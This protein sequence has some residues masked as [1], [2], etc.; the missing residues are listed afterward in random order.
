ML[1][2]NRLRIMKTQWSDHRN[3]KVI[4]L[5]HCLLNENTRYMGGAVRGGVNQEILDL[6]RGCSV[7]V[8]Q[9]ICPERI[10]WG[11]VYKMKMLQ[12]HGIGK[13]YLVSRVC[14]FCLPL[15][16][17]WLNYKM[18]WVAKYTAA[19]IKDYI[20][21]GMCVIGVVGVGGS[22]ACG[23]EHTPDLRRYF[24][25]A[26]KA[27][28]RTVTAKEHNSI[29]ENITHEGQGTFI[30]YLKRR[31]EKDNVNIPFFEY[32]LWDEMRGRDNSVTRKLRTH[33]AAEGLY[34]GTDST[35]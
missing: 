14:A 35:V 8:I 31:L 16:M 21:N 26:R 9:M 7:G 13:S 25:W 10:A 18:R 4:F 34:T 33:L 20:Q 17:F 15:F 1:S 32:N 30:R 5:A 3:K 29:V 12:F 2:S 28:L 19:E 23:V 22:P 24:E 11:G 6:L 27:D